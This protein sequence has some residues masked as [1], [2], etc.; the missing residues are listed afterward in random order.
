MDLISCRATKKGPSY[1]LVWL[2]PKDR[3]NPTGP[4][5]EKVIAE[6]R[7]CDTF[8]RLEDL[9]GDGRPELIGAL[10]WGKRLEVVSTDSTGRFDDASRLD[11][12]V[13][14]SDI[15]PVYGLE[16]EDL[17][18]DGKKV[19]QYIPDLIFD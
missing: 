14:E 18:G 6:Q 11:F 8:F 10:Y 3:S 17:N 2:T 9:D 13:V 7:G 16:F 5:E 12:T 1:A 19:R 15:G 4:W